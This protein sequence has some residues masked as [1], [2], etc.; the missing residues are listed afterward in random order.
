MRKTLCGGIFINFYVGLSMNTLTSPYLE[1]F[2]FEKDYVL[3]D[4][5]IELLGV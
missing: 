4:V 1:N 3:D 2:N 5:V